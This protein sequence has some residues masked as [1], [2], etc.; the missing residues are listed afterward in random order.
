[1]TRA[2]TPAQ[3]FRILVNHG[4]LA[5]WGGAFL[6][7][8]QVPFGTMNLEKR[9]RNLQR[10]GGAVK[11]GCGCDVWARLQDVE[12]DHIKNWASGGRSTLENGQPLRTYP[13]HRNEK[14][15]GEQVVTG[16]VRRVRRKLATRQALYEDKDPPRQGSQCAASKV[17]S[18]TAIR[19]ND[20]SVEDPCSTAR[21]RRSWP[22]R[23]FPKS[24]RAI[25][26]RP[27]PK[28]QRA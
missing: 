11:C 19:R 4:A 15:A 8:S 7:V 27:F 5:L 16:W 9:F 6:P 10:I 23:S 1:M 20:S 18:V 17:L 26:S 14:C 2:F 24:Y 28:T 12:F 25:P 3:K 13:C 21:P 22:T